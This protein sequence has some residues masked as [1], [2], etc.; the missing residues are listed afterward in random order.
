MAVIAQFFEAWHLFTLIFGEKK[1]NSHVHCG[2][3]KVRI[4][5]NVQ[6]PAG[7]YWSH[8]KVQVPYKVSDPV[9][10]SKSGKKSRIPYTKWDSG[11]SLM[12]PNV[13]VWRGLH[14]LWRV[15]VPDPGLLRRLRGDGTALRVTGAQGPRL[16]Q[17]AHRQ[18][19]GGGGSC[20]FSKY[21]F[22]YFTV[23]VQYYQ[24]TL[25]PLRPHCEEAQWRDSNPG[26]VV[27]R[28]GHWQLDYLPSWS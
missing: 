23:F 12:H 26:W 10:S 21:F 22:Y 27:M 3:S 17:D 24:C 6:D 9:K 2:G 19:G 7:S 13:S 25:P 5:P 14:Q 18:G 1:T 15:D 11:L 8:K 4:P 20:Y 16:H 28:Q